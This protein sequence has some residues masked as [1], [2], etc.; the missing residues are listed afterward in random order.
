[1][2]SNLTSADEQ[3][4]TIGVAQGSGSL[5]RILGPIFATGLYSI[6]FLP[7]GIANGLQSLSSAFA[8]P[9]IIPYVTCGIIAM[10]TGVLA[11]Q[12]LSRSSLAASR[13]AETTTAS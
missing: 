1:M 2:I 11:V 7:H 4:A 9:G 12:R 10:L 13:P 3:G 8:R 6:K 5:A